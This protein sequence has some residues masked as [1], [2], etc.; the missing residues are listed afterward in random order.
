MPIITYLIIAITVLISIQAN[1]DRMLYSRLVFYPYAINKD[2]QWYRFF[3]HAFI[4]SSDPSIF[5]IHLAGNMYTLYLFGARVQILQGVHGL[6]GMFIY[7][8]G[9]V[10]GRFFYVLLY[11]GAIMLSSFPS[12]EKHK[13][14]PHYAAVGA[15]GAVSAI[16]FAYILINPTGGLGLLFLPFY[17]PAFLFGLL[18]L[19]YSWYMAKRGRD[20]IGHDAHYWGSVFGFV[21]TVALKFQLL[22]LFLEQVRDYIGRFTGHS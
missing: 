10:K 4:H 13:H 22:A 3:T 20:N 1:N 2:R 19:L 17:I 9:G 18:Y 16:V 8:F 15:S 7:L 12:F 5:V 6:E 21:F 11:A 14:N